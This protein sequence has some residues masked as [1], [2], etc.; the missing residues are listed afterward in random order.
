MKRKNPIQPIHL[1]YI[2]NH[3]LRP[4]F[5]SQNNGAHADISAAN[6]PSNE[7]AR[8]F[9]R[10]DLIYRSSRLVA[11]DDDDK[12]RRGSDLRAASFS[13]FDFRPRSGVL[14][15][16]SVDFPYVLIKA[17]NRGREGGGR[18][19]MFNEEKR[20]PP[21]G[22]VRRMR[23]KWKGGWTVSVDGGLRGEGRLD[24]FPSL[25]THRDPGLGFVP[26]HGS[27]LRCAGILP[28]SRF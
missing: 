19:T 11:A 13:V 25:C 5:R 28:V 4:P 14:P 24:S 15:G 16:P 9:N 27:R 6:F 20:T 1:T 8:H 21:A 22:L 17:I 10:L 18:G 26:S 12:S 7:V 2:F 3:G 23:E